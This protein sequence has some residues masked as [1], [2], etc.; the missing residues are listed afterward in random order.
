MTPD[1]TGLAIAWE[2]PGCAPEPPREP[3][4]RG[5]AGPVDTHTA[6]SVDQHAVEP[7]LPQPRGHRAGLL[8]PAC[9][10]SGCFDEGGLTW[11]SRLP[12]VSAGSAAR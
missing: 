5:D 12:V 3:R 7:G 4:R 1:D 8:W 11:T 6:F 10:C 2:S 9:E